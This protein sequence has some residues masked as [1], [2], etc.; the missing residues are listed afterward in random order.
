MYIPFEKYDQ[1]TELSDFPRNKVSEKLI[2]TAKGF[3]ESNDMEELLLNILPDPNRTPHGPAEIV[4]ILTLQ[5]SY[6]KP[7]TFTGSRLLILWIL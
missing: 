7:H 2:T 6:K 1:F 5:L 4:D 3:H